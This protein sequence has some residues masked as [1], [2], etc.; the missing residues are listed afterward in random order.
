MQHD[1]GTHVCTSGASD[2]SA[3]PQPSLA[4]QEERLFDLCCRLDDVHELPVGVKH[5]LE[6]SA[7]GCYP[8]VL[9][10]PSGHKRP[11][12]RL[13]PSQTCSH[14]LGPWRCTVMDSS[15]LQL[16]ACRLQQAVQLHRSP[17]CGCRSSK[18]PTMACPTPVVLQQCSTYRPQ[19][20]KTSELTNDSKGAPIGHAC[21]LLR[22][23]A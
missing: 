22:R 15:H 9:P 7:H 11:C 1:T 21:P 20:S 19:M 6:L 23:L 4:A 18:A 5:C 10:K 13:R 3:R 8:P 2:A 14:T 17:A 12:G 16:K